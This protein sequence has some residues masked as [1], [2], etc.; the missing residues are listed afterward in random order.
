MSDVTAC[1]TIYTWKLHPS[2]EVYT[3]LRSN[4][5]LSI[6]LEVLNR[7]IKPVNHGRPSLNTPCRLNEQALNS[8]DI[9]LSC[10]VILFDE[11]IN[12]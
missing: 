8:G 1:H 2:S 7:P 9:I 4:Q 3:V 10:D 5:R 11:Y 12:T 6:N